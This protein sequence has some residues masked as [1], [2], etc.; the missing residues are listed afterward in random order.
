MAHHRLHSRESW[1]C[2]HQLAGTSCL[3]LLCAEDFP[4]L[5]IFTSFSALPTICD[6]G[7]DAVTLVFSLDWARRGVG[8]ETTGALSML[9]PH[10]TSFVAPQ[11]PSATCASG[12]CHA[13]PCYRN[14][15]N[16]SK[17]STLSP[18]AH[19][20]HL[21]WSCLRHLEDRPSSVLVA[22]QVKVLLWG[23]CRRYSDG[24]HGRMMTWEHP[25]SR[26][27]VLCAISRV[28]IACMHVPACMCL[29]AHS[30]M[31]LSGAKAA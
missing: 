4:Q 29:H 9:L 13:A 11:S 8:C 25:N 27:H 7:P 2:W 17:F 26:M 5:Q 12:S 3:S 21:H 6:A 14:P 10:L 24:P 19:D 18:P 22:R 16:G 15:S 28:C 23:T 30:C 1:S 20:Q 31:E